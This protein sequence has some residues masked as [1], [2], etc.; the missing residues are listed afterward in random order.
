MYTCPRCQGSLSTTSMGIVEIEICSGCGGMWLD[1]NELEI[2]V[3]KAQ[4]MLSHKE[5]PAV[6]DVEASTE[7]D[8]DMKCPKCI[9]TSLRAFIYAFDSGIELDKCPLCKGLW[10]DKSELEQLSTKVFTVENSA[11]RDFNVTEIN[12]KSS[13]R[14]NKSFLEALGAFLLGMV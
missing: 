6:K 1:A 7:K 3:E 5:L 8:I 11:T 10:L 13:Q 12:A 4:S 14:K 9:D 2:V